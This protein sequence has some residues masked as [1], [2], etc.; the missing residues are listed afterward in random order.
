[1][2]ECKHAKHTP[3]FS[4]LV[5]TPKIYSI[6][7]PKPPWTHRYTQGKRQSGPQKDEGSIRAH[8]PLPQK[9]YH[10][11]VTAFTNLAHSHSS[12]SSHECGKRFSAV[13]I[14]KWVHGPPGTTHLWFHLPFSKTSTKI[15]KKTSNV[16]IWAA[17]TDPC[18]IMSQLYTWTS[19][20]LET[21]THANNLHLLGKGGFDGCRSWAACGSP[22]TAKLESRWES[23]ADCVLY[24]VNICKHHG[25]YLTPTKHF[26]LPQTDR[27]L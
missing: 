12:P 11:Y 2:Q 3:V 15:R 18:S 26:P 13:W 16:N 9:C 14:Q 8:P 21:S 4:I 5:F 17:A 24:P 23:S 25:I 27:K 22:L 1:M 6:L 10:T 7:K 19:L 20:F